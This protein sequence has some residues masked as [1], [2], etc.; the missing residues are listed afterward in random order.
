[1]KKISH[2]GDAGLSKISKTYIEDTTGDKGVKNTD[3][4]MNSTAACEDISQSEVGVATSETDGGFMSCAHFTGDQ[5]IDSNSQNHETIHRIQVVAHASPSVKC[6][7]QVEHVSPPNVKGHQQVEYV[8]PPNVKGHQQVEYVSPPNVKGHQQVEHVSSNVKDPQHAPT[9]NVKH[10]HQVEAPSPNVKVHQQVEHASPNVKHHQQVEHAST[11]KNGN[12]DI[13]LNQRTLIDSNRND[14]L[15]KFV[16]SEECETFQENTSSHKINSIN[17]QRE[18]H[19]VDHQKNHVSSYK[20][21]NDRDLNNLS[22]QCS[23]SQTR[24]EQTRCDTITVHLNS[25]DSQMR[26]KREFDEHSDLLAEVIQGVYKS[27]SGLLSLD[28]SPATCATEHT[29]VKIEEA[30][31]EVVTCPQYCEKWTVIDGEVKHEPT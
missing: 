9:P 13:I 14:F 4:D 30:I 22:S 7:Q 21:K 28:D 17:H 26:V 19:N 23:N 24:T 10:H 25:V 6:H 12:D 18:D 16:H 29:E 3:V 1:M 20:N 2:F 5:H 11:L 15:Q 27:G 8:S 31:T